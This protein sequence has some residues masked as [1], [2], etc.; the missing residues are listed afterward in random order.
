MNDDEL[1]RALSTALAPPAVATAGD[2]GAR[3]RARARRARTE[4]LAVGGTVV[5][6]L[7]VLLALGLVRGI[8]GAAAPSPAAAEPVGFHRLTTPLTVALTHQVHEVTG[9]CAAGPRLRCV[10]PSTVLTVDEVVGLA[11]SELPERGALVLATLTA[12]DAATVAAVTE[13]ESGESLTIGV[14]KGSYPAAV[15]DGVI[16]IRTPTPRIAS[17]LVDELDPVAPRPA[18]TGPGRFDV[19]LQIWEVASQTAS[20]CRV[21]PATKGVLVADT[22]GTCLVLTGPALSIDA[23]VVE[24]VPPQAA[25]EGWMVTLELGPDDARRMGDFSSRHTESDIWY[26]VG[27]R[28]ISGG[29]YGERLTTLFGIGVPDEAS[30][31]SLID[32]LRR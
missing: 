7:A 25:N 13:G 20:P 21:S 22:A 10:P 30:A 12:V 9:T 11:V 24:T 6:V 8:G 14:G 15:V 26:V 18:R 2:A 4:Q 29:H 3:L 32:R 31:A 17:G 27:G 16:R 23:A 5:L 1:G 19:P 28:L